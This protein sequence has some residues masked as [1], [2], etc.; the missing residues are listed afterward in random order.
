[1]ISGFVVM[2]EPLTHAHHVIHRVAKPAI[3]LNSAMIVGPNEQVDFGTAAIAQQ[4]LGLGNN[5][6]REPA[7]LIVRGHSEI[8]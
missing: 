8:I 4:P 5:A 2:L 1:M 7:S 3:E 6:A